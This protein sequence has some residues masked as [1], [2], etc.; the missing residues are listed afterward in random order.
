VSRT[1]RGTGSAAAAVV[2]A[3]LLAA[4][5][6]GGAAGGGAESTDGRIAVVATSDVWGSIVS[7][8]GAGRVA[9]TSI[10]DSPAKDPH[11]YQA[12][13]R[14][15]LSVSRAALVV[16]NGGGYDDFLARLSEGTGG[17]VLDAVRLS[18]HDAGVPGFNEHVW[19]DLPTVDRVA[20]AVSAVLQRKDPAHRADFRA[21]LARFHAAT[22][23][24]A[25][26]ESGIRRLGDG[27]GVAV[28]EPVPLYVTAAC[29]LVN[30]TPAAFSS[31]VEDGRDVP[32]GVLQM[33][34]D[35]VA[36]HAVAV[37]A[38]NEQTEGAVTDRIVAAARAA[39]VPVVGF[40]ETLPDGESYLGMF[41]AELTAL[42]AA[43]SR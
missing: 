24:L 16:E 11:E 43:V 13:V 4:C 22:A 35:L 18:G 10:L 34:L 9:V 42:R 41:H 29:G 2:V 1:W 28:T 3:V 40:R 37:L 26:A 5:T 27:R 32:P 33:Q 30:R 36:S 39:G 12:T 31:A 38:V 23:A 25:R 19:Y 6:S 14:D 20:D 15:R 17:V 8:V 7:D 21:A